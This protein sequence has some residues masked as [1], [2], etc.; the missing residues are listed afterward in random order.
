MLLLILKDFSSAA[1]AS[2]SAPGRNDTPQLWQEAELTKQR[3]RQ[4]GQCV[5]LTFI[6]FERAYKSKLASFSLFS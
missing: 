4:S 6:S 3:R 2:R 1:D 5:R